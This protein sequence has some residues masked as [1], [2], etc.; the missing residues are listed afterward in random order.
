M[1]IIRSI[2]FNILFY[3]NMTILAFPGLAVPS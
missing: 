1:I 3:L 2:A